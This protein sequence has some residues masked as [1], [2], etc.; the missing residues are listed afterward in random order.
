MNRKISIPIIPIIVAIIVVIITIVIVMLTRKTE[1]E[2]S[3]LIKIYNKML[4]KQTYSFTR[5][6]FEEKNKLVTY[7][8]INKTLIDMYNSG[9][10]LS[11]LILDGDTYLISHANKEYYVY[12]SNNSDEEIL[13]DNLKNIIDLEYTTGKE[14]IYGKTYNYE[15]Y[16]GVSSFLISS[17]NNMDTNSVKTRFYFDKNDLVYLKTI[18]DIINEETGETTQAE[19]LLTVEVKYEVEDSIFEIPNNYAEN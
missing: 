15:E 7:R 10:H 18:Y 1:N 14:K 16:K 19:E 11:T 6:D 5:Y 12:P 13:T 9:E 8:K 2:I 3:R 4:E 17:T